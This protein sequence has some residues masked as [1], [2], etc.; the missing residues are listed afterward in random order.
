[1]AQNIEKKEFEKDKPILESTVRRSKD[2]RYV[3]FKTTITYIKPVRYVEKVLEP[4]E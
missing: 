2:G 3:I 4:D 1:M